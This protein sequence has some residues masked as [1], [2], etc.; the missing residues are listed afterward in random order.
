[1]KKYAL[2]LLIMALGCSSSDKPADTHSA[3]PTAHIESDPLENL[4][5]SADQ[6][7][8]ANLTIGSLSD[9]IL[10][11]K[12][13]V[14]GEIGVAPNN[15]ATVNALMPGIIKKINIYPGDF[16]TKGQVIAEIQHPDI[17]NWQENY[18]KAKTQADLTLKEYQRQTELINQKV[19]FAKKMQQAEAEYQTAKA[20][21]AL[22]TRKLQLTGIPLPE[23]PDQM[24]PTLS[25]TALISGYITE[26]KVNLGKYVELNT[27]IADI[28]D[29][30]H[31]HLHLQVFE[32][33]LDKIKEKQR[34]LFHPSFTATECE[35]E[36]IRIGHQFSAQN[37]S[38]E[39]HGHV[40]NAKGVRLLPGMFI[41]GYVECNGVSAQ[42]VP[43]DAL[44]EIKKESYLLREKEKGHFEAVAVRT[45]SRQN[46]K[47]AI[48]ATDHQSLSG[49]NWVL[50]GAHR[51]W[52]ASKLK[53]EPEEAG[54]GH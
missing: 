31:L 41:T 12:V 10:T 9:T 35:G 17:L 26:V 21:L 52:N 11:E 5:L 27:P 39:L 25:L 28:V 40:T 4:H 50:H 6:R 13:A 45:G 49:N 36:I 2:I 30:T 20:N 53:S 43:E 33:D 47:V 8:R 15:F 7:Q 42:V 3:K 14:T 46:G 38:I 54:H 18:L 32:N 16:V 44:L 19:G 34:V 23:S 22:L 37:R 29:H 24:R 51:I 1:M 48:L